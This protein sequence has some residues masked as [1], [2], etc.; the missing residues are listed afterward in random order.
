MLAASVWRP[1]LLLAVVG[2]A[3]A[4]L[5]AVL[6][7]RLRNASGL[8]AG[9]LVALLGPLFLLLLSL[10][11]R[12]AVRKVTRRYR[13]AVG[14]GL[15]LAV[16]GGGVAYVAGR[17]A[18]DR[19][20]YTIEV[21]SAAMAPRI[22]SGDRVLVSPLLLREPTLGE[23]VAVAPFPRAEP[24][25]ARGRVFTVLRVVGRAGDWVGATS[26]GYYRCPRP[27]DIAKP[28]TRELG[29]R[30][31]DETGYTV[32]RTQPFGPVPVP[33]GTVYLLG[34]DR[35]EPGDS[36][37]FGPVPVGALAGRVVATVWPTERLAV[38]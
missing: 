14:L 35:Q 25:G 15:V 28:I 22:A 5:V 30:F 19:V 4:A 10:A 26:R 13:G 20:G 29:C 34:D 31:P 21:P 36:R 24:F 38:R 17:W 18:L 7:G 33:K 8:V 6:D 2:W 1:L 9:V 32:S 27:P 11:Q 37:E 12:R 16:L 3:L 23:I